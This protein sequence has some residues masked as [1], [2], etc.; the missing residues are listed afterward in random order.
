MVNRIVGVDLGG[1]QMRVALMDTD[2]QLLARANEPTL[3]HQGADSIIPRLLDLIASV[4]D[5]SD[6]PVD[7]ISVVSPG[8]VD[9]VAGVVT[10]APNL[11]G[12]RDLPLGA[13]V[14]QR[15]PHIPT[16]LANDAN[17]A[18]LA[19]VYIGAAVGHRHAVYITVST[20]IGGGIII[21]GKLFTG[22]MG[23]AGE[24][25]HM[26]VT[27]DDG[28]VSSLEEEA[29][30]PALARYA[31]RRIRSGAQSRITEMVNG[32]L[33]AITGRIVGD[34]AAAGD[35]LALE[36]A[37]RAGRIIGYAIT[38]LMH[39]LNPTIFVIG[40]GVTNLGELLFEPMRIASRERAL[41][42]K[43]YEASDIVRAKLGDDVGLIGAAALVLQELQPG[44]ED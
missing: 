21:D 7:A 26:L 2:F 44:R 39:L 5:T 40:G 4:V 13:I 35:A 31:A 38:S 9:P 33:E 18:A 41:A 14:N 20:G 28:S 6:Q 29:A 19:E 32:N 36:T 3:A 1:T 11:P 17:A 10:Y 15:F 12:W 34:A 24:I 25:G 8:P 30:G 42:S 22:A 27:I 16:F 37:T 43:Y 23:L